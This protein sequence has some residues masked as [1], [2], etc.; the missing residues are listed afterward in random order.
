MC[1]YWGAL[2]SNKNDAPRLND[3]QAPLLSQIMDTIFYPNSNTAYAKIGE[4]EALT[5]SE[6]DGAIE[7]LRTEILGDALY[8]ACLVFR[9]ETNDVYAEARVSS[10]DNC[11]DIHEY[12]EHTEE[13]RRMCY[14]HPNN[15]CAKT[16]EALRRMSSYERHNYIIEEYSVVG[17]GEAYINDLIEERE[18]IVEER[19]AERD[20]RRANNEDVDDM[21]ILSFDEEVVV[22]TDDLRY[23]E[24][25]VEGAYA[26][27][28][29]YMRYRF[30]VVSTKITDVSVLKRIFV[31]FM[32]FASKQE[33]RPPF[34]KW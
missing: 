32:V 23:R 19:D 11:I 9:N 30:E 14:S 4:L 12:R 6:L 8:D 33:P 15:D 27:M 18:Q 24:D 10:Y 29:E 2:G 20:R 7:R 16:Y 21:S 25:F 28:N 13:D 34:L 31:D 26:Y 3:Y 17:D 22:T 1:V 5:Q